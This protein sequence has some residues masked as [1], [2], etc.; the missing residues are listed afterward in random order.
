MSNQNHK[1]VRVNAQFFRYAVDTACRGRL[2]T[3]GRCM[4]F[5]REFLVNP[6]RYSFAVEVPY[7]ACRGIGAC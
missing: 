1:N 6:L 5:R 2:L 4:E 7:E 3:S